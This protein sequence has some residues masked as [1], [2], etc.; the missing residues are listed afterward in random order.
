MKEKKKR[1]CDGNC[2]E[3][4]YAAVC[5]PEIDVEYREIKGEERRSYLNECD[6]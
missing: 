1:Y 3:C 5:N 2:M 6:D 4:F